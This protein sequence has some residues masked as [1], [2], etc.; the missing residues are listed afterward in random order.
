MNAQQTID[1]ENSGPPAERLTMD[2]TT[3]SLLSLMEASEMMATEQDEMVPQK[4][5]Y[6]SSERA[7]HRPLIQDSGEARES[8]SSG[9]DDVNMVT[10]STGQASTTTTATN[11]TSSGDDPDG[12]GGSSGPISDDFG[13]NL[14]V[15]D[16]VHES[17]A[18]HAAAVARLPPPETSGSSFFY[19]SSE[20]GNSGGE[21]GK[22]GSRHAARKVQPRHSFKTPGSDQSSEESGEVKPKK[23]SASQLLSGSS[24]SKRRRYQE[25][26]DIETG[27]V[28][29]EQNSSGSG[30]EGGYAGEASSSDKPSSCSSPSISSSGDERG[31]R[32]HKAHR[33]DSI[34]CSSSSLDDYDDLSDPGNSSSASPA[35]DSSSIDNS[36]DELEEEDDDRLLPRKLGGLK[37]EI[38]TRRKV[39]GHSMLQTSY[40]SAAFNQSVTR[41]AQKRAAVHSAIDIDKPKNQIGQDMFGRPAILCLSSDLM[42]Q[43]LSYLNPPEVHEILAMPLSK[44]WRSAFTMPPD[45]WRVLCLTEPFNARFD[46]E[47][48]D[49]EDCSFPAI[50][51]QEVRHLLGK[52]RLL[53]T[54]FV[55]CMKY[56]D[57]IKD[58][59]RHGRPPSLVEY[60]RSSNPSS[61]SVRTNENLKTFLARARG[62]IVKNKKKQKACEDDSSM[63]SH[64]GVTDDNSSVESL[65]PAFAAKKKK[66]G[67]SKPT[68][69]HSQLTQRLLGPS[70]TG[71]AGNVNLP[72]SCAIY[73][74]VNW[75]VAFADIEGIQTMCLKVLP[76]LLEDES[77]RTTAQR[78]GLTD[79]VLRG[80]VVFP[81]SVLLHTAAF[82]TIVLLARPLGGREGMLFHCSM[83][84]SYGIFNEG[85]R[86]GKNGIAVM[87]DSM[88]KFPSDEILQAM[89]CWSLV[90]IALAPSQKAVLVKLGGISVVAN[91]MM[92]HPLNAEVQFRAL[93]ALINLVI[94]C[95]FQSNSCSVLLSGF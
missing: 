55:R 19:S 65:P 42:A 36:S 57:K 46:D 58:D 63:E 82:H 32:K 89:S 51:E 83:V 17:T 30:T 61:V 86:S 37:M 43:C 48:S 95:K 25:S 26:K 88:R 73:S 77:Q 20:K 7:R 64:I 76:F 75:M 2:A 33:S 10:A 29:D 22:S 50:P 39:Q 1:T 78:A 27:E 41:L 80:M 52:Y 66:K 38:A 11:T 59:A 93:F 28:G 60:G 44:E 69:G 92:Q 3:Q 74:I 91:A 53:Y 85:S 45:L 56:L 90:N 71:Q 15:E 13:P 18:S 6:R 49:S 31:C 5:G 16:R 35:F 87:L 9:Q 72:W 70:K 62:M 47:D 81:N 67:K 4:R 94:P 84:N 12:N 68:Y 24:S 23:R 14:A 34:E 40:E 79:I 21:G 54:S 8:T